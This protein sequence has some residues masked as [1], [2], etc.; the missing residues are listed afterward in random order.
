VTLLA[1]ALLA[2]GLCPSPGAQVAPQVAPSDDDLRAELE[3]ER[4]E[5]RKLELRVATLERLLGPQLEQDD[6]EIQL[7]GLLGPGALPSGAPRPTVFP[8]AYNPR[9]GVFMDATIEGGEWDDELGEESD[10][11]SLRETEL[12]FRLPIAP[13]AQGVAIITLE[14]AGAGEFETHIEEGYADI[15]VGGLL[16]NDWDATAKVGRFRPAFGRNNQLHLHDQL[17]VTLPDA[18]RN[19]L[20]GEGLIGD[21]VSVHVPLHHT[22]TASGRGHTTSLDLAVI[23]GEVFTGEESLFGE[24]AEEAGLELDSDS[25]M[26]VARASHFVELDSL[27]DVEIGVS[28]MQRLGSEAVTTDAGTAI[29]PE[30]IGADI[31]WRSRDDETGVGSWLLQAETIRTKVDYD[32]SAAPGFPTGSQKRD[33]WWVTAQR[34]VSPTVY[35]GMRYG[36]SEMYGSGDVDRSIA[37]YVSWYADEFFRIRA[38]LERLERTVAGGPDIDEVWRAMLQ[39]SWNFGSHQ[40]HPYWVNR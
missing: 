11:M 34:Q 22:E 32:G 31:T 23:N 17:L 7:Q 35:M 5:R 4:A 38:Q 36:E 6:L 9:I 13:F 15:A 8:S 1:A 25:P 19:L 40:P 37:P 26:V 27:S 21:G 20:G 28:T 12:D 39:F 14:D 24:L 29:D 33:G 3:R 10:R 2:G 16:D 18:V 30:L